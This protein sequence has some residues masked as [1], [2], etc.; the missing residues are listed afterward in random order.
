MRKSRCAICGTPA[1]RPSEPPIMTNISRRYGRSSLSNTFAN[2]VN[3]I[4]AHQIAANT[5]A[6]PIN[7]STACPEA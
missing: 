1:A 7:P 4:Q 2:Q 5:T 6:K 3:A